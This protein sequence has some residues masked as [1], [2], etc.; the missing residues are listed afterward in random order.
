[1]THD[2][3]YNLLGQLVAEL[4]AELFGTDVLQPIHHK[5]IGRVMACVE[6]YL[7]STQNIQMN[8]AA[9]SLSGP[10]KR[11]NGQTVS[12]LLHLALAN[13]EKAASTPLKG[14]FLPAATPFDAFIQVGKVLEQ[15]TNDFLIVDP[16]ADEKLLDQFARQANEGIAIRILAEEGKLKSTLSP[17][18]ERWISQ[19]GASRPLEVRAATAG[20]LHDRLIVIDGSKAWAIGQSF[21]A[22]AARSPTTILRMDEEPAN[23]KI[24]AMEAI[25]KV[26][27]AI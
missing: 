6:P 4:P 7:S 1:M 12:V 15:S 27:I 20:T 8:V 26:A 19:F 23:L 25:W 21:N 16:Y 5:W 9:T 3:A 22:L 17:S 24:S 18:K 13:A 11:S 10:L 14:M 2:Q